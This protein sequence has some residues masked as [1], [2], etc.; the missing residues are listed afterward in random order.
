MGYF[1]YQKMKGT[2]DF[3]D[4]DADKM[5]E[6]T[7]IASSVAS[8]YGCKHIETPIFEAREVFEKNV[9]EETDVV[10]KE[11]YT[12]KD[13]GDRDCT[14]RPEGTAA[15][16]RFFIENKMY[17]NPGLTKFYYYGPMFRYERQQVGRYRQFNQF[18]IEVYGNSSYLLDVDVIK[19]AYDIFKKFGIN[20]V[21]LKV[22]SIGNFESRQNYSKALKE[23]FSKYIDTM[24]ED[25]KRRIDT[26]PMRILDCKVDSD[27]EALKH[28]PCIHDYLTL[29]SKEYFNGILKGLEALEIPYIVDYNLV[30]GLDYY[31]DTVFEF[32]IVSDD[33]LNGL[34]LGGGGK[35]AGMIKSM[36]G[37]DMPGIGYAIGLERL[38]MILDTIGYEWKYLNNDDPV[39]IMALD[40]ESK[41]ESMKLASMLRNNGFKV[42]ID[43]QS[44]SMKSQFKLA[45]RVKAKFIVIIGE[46]ERLTKVYSVKNTVLRTQEKVK[47]KDLINYIRG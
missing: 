15:V 14:L 23:Y 7:R 46:E 42:E 18:G 40:D 39:V 20:N 33:Q 43:Y 8:V 11:M 31:T 29:E 19:S 36:C 44:T 30:R 16:A 6:L 32:T 41:I 10:S 12:F 28:V 1:N 13:K 34:A 22:N 9:G 21:V 25:C 45:D 4:L 35:Y 17:A 3:Y 24:C 47:E 26:N 38:K 27:H 37:V 2:Q 5:S